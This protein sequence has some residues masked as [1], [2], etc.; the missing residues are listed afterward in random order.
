M[1]A[2]DGTLGYWPE[3]DDVC[4]SDPATKSAESLMSPPTDWPKCFQENATLKRLLGKKGLAGKRCRLT[5]LPSNEDKAK[6][7]A[8]DIFPED[9]FGNAE[10]VHQVCGWEVIKGY[11]VYELRGAEAV[12]YTHLTLPTIL[13][14]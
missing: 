11:A 9:P 4:S 3:P 2:S 5:A 13:L 6:Y 1:T 7:A 8:V 10:K 14:V 12:S